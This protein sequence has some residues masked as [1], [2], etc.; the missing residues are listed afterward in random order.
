MVPVPQPWL[1]NWRAPLAVVLTRLEARRAPRGALPLL[2]AGLVGA[3][4]ARAV[5]RLL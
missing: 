1:Q 4:A 3:L 5:C 2:G